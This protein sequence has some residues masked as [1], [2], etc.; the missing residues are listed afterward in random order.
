MRRR[1]ASS[2][3]AMGGFQLVNAFVQL[4]VI[5]A[6]ALQWGL[7]LYGQWLM[8]VTIPLFISASDFG[9]STAASNRIIGEIARSETAE[10]LVTFQ[11]ALRMVLQLTAGVTAIAALAFLLIPAQSLA[12]EGGMDG[13]A[14]RAVL[15]VM[16][17]YGLTTIQEFLFMGVAKAQHRQA[18]AMAIRGLTTLFEGLLVLLLVSLG[19]EPLA[20][21]VCYLGVRTIGVGAQVVLA[22]RSANWL[23]IGF[24]KAS[25]SRL[26]ELLRPAFAAMVLPLSFAT[27]LQGTA[28]A[29]GLAAG[30]A[31]VPL[32]TSLRTVARVGIQ[33]TNMFIV[34]LMPEI[35]AA[36]ARGDRPLLARM[37]GL[38]LGANLFAGPVIG[39]LV[40]FFGA[41]LLHLWTRGVIQP[42]QSMITLVGISLVFATLWNPMAAML[43]SINR[44]ESY[45]YAFAVVAAGG[46]GLTWFL[47][48]HY[49]VTGAGAANLVVDSLMFA[50]VVTSL[51]RN[52]GG[53][54]F[55]RAAVL[56]VLPGRFRGRKLTGTK[57]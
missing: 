41:D 18:A 23:R 9:F 38:L 53:L 25:A 13:S 4:A 32:F 55:S 42:P 24:A 31:A 51:R 47:T 21:A 35:T 44:H 45:S 54:E 52:I 19:G 48:L 50:I 10:A 29:I 28:L 22:R 11:T 20:I 7:A 6:M 14:A 15:I 36:H 49:G 17:A 56:S 39:A 3:A 46:V 5:P 16:T 26:R 8:L 33:L 57:K 30:P 34:P 27:Y 40:V 37:G 2:V 1:F 43:L 12:A